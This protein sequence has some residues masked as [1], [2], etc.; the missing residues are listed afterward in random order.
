MG[1]FGPDPYTDA[2][3]GVFTRRRGVWIARTAL[4]GLGTVELC[5][6]G[7]R[8][9]PNQPSLALAHEAALQYRALREEI[10]RLLF[11]H[12]EPYA[13]AVREGEL[14]ADAFN[15]AALRGPDDVWSHVEVL[16]VHVDTAR[17]SFPIEVQVQVAWDEEHTLGLR[18]RDGRLVEL[19]GSVLPPSA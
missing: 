6:A 9:A 16:A 8:K 15:P 4:P 1:L 12:L 19:C 3:F 5:V 17:Q 11:E 18:I 2:H 10:G 14:E 7:D 13:D